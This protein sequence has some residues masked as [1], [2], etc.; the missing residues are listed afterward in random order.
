MWR[1]IVITFGFLGFSFYELSGGADYQAATGSRQAL[2]AERAHADAQRK[3]AEAQS[4]PAE[5]APVPVVTATPE[6]ADAIVVL[7]SLNTSTDVDAPAQKPAATTPDTPVVDLAKAE[8]LVSPEV[9]KPT[10]DL[11]EVTGNRVNLR[12]GPGTDYPAVGKL[13]RGDTVQVISETGDGWIKLR[14]SETGRIGYMADFL[15]TASN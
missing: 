9:A 12:R 4:K 1:F 5:Q 6:P 15:L 13:A 7:T 14:V 2:A 11:R 8:E 3:L 10:L